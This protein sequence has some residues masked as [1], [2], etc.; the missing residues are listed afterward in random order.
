LGPPNRPRRRPVTR[1]TGRL[2]T[3]QPE[4]RRRHHQDR[5]HCEGE[6]SK[7]FAEKGDFTKEGKLTLDSKFA[8]MPQRAPVP[9]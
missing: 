1:P 7:N 3:C 9:R 2:E 5:L 4:R 6:L 8:K